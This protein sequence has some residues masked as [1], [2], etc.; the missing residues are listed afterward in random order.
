[1]RKSPISGFIDG[2]IGVAYVP[3]QFMQNRDTHKLAI[4]EMCVAV[5]IGGVE[6]P[7]EP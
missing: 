7:G 2:Q 5:A 4:D 6:A 3:S 1:M